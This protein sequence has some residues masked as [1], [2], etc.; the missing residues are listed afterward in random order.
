M[1]E[2]R[3]DHCN[4][5]A[6]IV[7]KNTTPV[8]I[9]TPAIEVDVVQPSPITKQTIDPVLRSAAVHDAVNNLNRQ[10]ALADKEGLRVSIEADAGGMF[11]LRTYIQFTVKVFQEI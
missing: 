10:L 7:K 4:D 6:K 8:T 9:S 1:A 3:A 11:S 5:C 2:D